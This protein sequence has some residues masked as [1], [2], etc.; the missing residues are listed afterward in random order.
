[1]RFVAGERDVRSGILL[2]DVPVGGGGSVV[3]IVD[4]DDPV[5]DRL[6]SLGFLPGTSVTVLRRAPLG[7]P[8]VYELRGYQLCLRR[9][10][11]ERVLVT[12]AE[13]GS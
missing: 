9:R 8:T 12:G 11:A 1:M 3:G 4:R 2:S 5:G 10:E 13:A 6:A 7:D